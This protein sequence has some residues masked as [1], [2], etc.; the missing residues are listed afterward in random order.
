MVCAIAHAARNPDHC[1]KLYECNAVLV[2]LS[3]VP[4]LDGAVL[5]EA[6]GAF[7]HLARHPACACQLVANDGI[8]M[9]LDML[10]KGD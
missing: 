9:L 4:L 1:Q 7:T 5:A 8:P 3:M 2:L 10:D 6:A